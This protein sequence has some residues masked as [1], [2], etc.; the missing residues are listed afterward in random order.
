MKIILGLLLVALCYI[1]CQSKEEGKIIETA[2]HTCWVGSFKSDMSEKWNRSHLLDIEAVRLDTTGRKSHYFLKLEVAT[3]PIGSIYYDEID[4]V[5]KNLDQLDF[6]G[7]SSDANIIRT[8][9]TKGKLEFRA[10]PGGIVICKVE[11]ERT[12]ES[13]FFVSKLSEI[14]ELR[15]LI[16]IG[17]QKLDSLKTVI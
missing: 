4:L 9:S 13:S 10:D 8:F 14:P 16:R 12:Q 2:R 15:K 5:L 1:S 17:K 7:I 3:D 6:S 11:S